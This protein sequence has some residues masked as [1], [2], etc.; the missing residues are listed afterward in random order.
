MIR[1]MTGFGAA[2]VE[3]GRLRG[4]VTV[5]A[6]NHR[7]LD[8]DVHLPRRLQAFEPDLRRAVQGRVRRGRVEVWVHVSSPAV[9]GEASVTARPVVAELVR[10]L[11][12]VRQE[13]GLAGDVT[14]SDLTAFPMAFEVV[15]GTLAADEE[16][17]TSLVEATTR[18]LDALDGMRS[19]EGAH[20]GTD[21]R[22][23]L[24]AIASSVGRLEDA[25]EASR[26]ARRD[27]LARRAAALKG[28]LGADEGR[29][30]AEL[31]RLVDRADVTEELQRLASH[32]AQARDLLAGREA[33]GKR[34]DFLAQEM[35]RE[36]NT[37]GSKAGVAELVQEVV[38]LKAEVERFREQA[39]NAE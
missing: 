5:R 20:L 36:A 33:C 27:A 13:H 23:A 2:A 25:A 3:A 22:N 9:Q 10:A 17:R 24:D 39:Q 38:G 8:L 21:L 4:A 26:P 16:D 6:V 18:A 30:Y 37:V 15:D 29:L 1:S 35:A 7:Y 34:L 14:L 28:E 12:Q 32:V 11:R 19:A 31:A